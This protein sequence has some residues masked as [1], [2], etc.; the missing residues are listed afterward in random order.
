[1][2][3]S[4]LIAQIM[5]LRELL[6]SFLGN[7]LV[8]GIV[9]ANWLLLEAGG[10]LLVGRLL[11]RRGRVF[12]S[13][14]AT[15]L[16]FALALPVSIYG[17]RVFKSVVLR[18]P[19][20]A[21]GFLPILGLSLLILL[22]TAVPHGALFTMG[23]RLRSLYVPDAGNSP[24]GSRTSSS[25]FAS[26]RA[27]SIGRVYVLESLGSILGGAAFTFVLVRR[28]D[29]L[30]VAWG[31]SLAN[32]LISLIL[33]RP[34]R[35]TH[36]LSPEPGRRS[37]R[38][39]ALLLVLIF[40]L[41]LFSPLGEPIHLSS[42]RR[43]WPGLEP[44][45]SENSIYGNITVTRTA[46][47]RTF[48]TDGVPAATVPVPDIGGIETFVH[49]PMLLHHRPESVLIAGGGAGGMIGEVLKHPVGRIDYVELDPL[50]IQLIL[51][52]GS[53]A[54][55]RE[56]TDPRV[57]IHHSDARLFL[58]R[59]DRR[60]DVVFIGIGAPQELQ[61]N[62]LFTR[63]FFS[64][65][66]EKLGARGLLA[67]SLPGSQTYMG[68]ELR[69]LNGCILDTLESVF[70]R[71]RVVPGDENL[72][73]ASDSPLSVQGSADDLIARL[74][75]RNIAANLVSP[76]YIEY[77]LQPQWL[78]DYRRAVDPLPRRINSDFR[79]LAVFY[80]LSYWNALYSPAVGEV[81]RRIE[82]TRPSTVAVLILIATLGVAVLSA[83]GRTGRG[84]PLFHAIA[85]TGFCGMI[86][87][88][89]VILTF[90]TLFGYLYVQIGLLVTVFM[91]GTVMGS[92][93]ATRLLERREGG[94]TAFLAAELCLALFAMLLP[95]ALIGP[96]RLLDQP[97]VR[98]LHHALFLLVSLASGALTGFQFPLAA[99]LH[100]RSAA[101]GGAEIPSAAEQLG[102]R[103]G[104]EAGD[105]AGVLY[106]ADLLGGYFGGLV[107]GVILLPILGLW[108]TCLILAMIKGGSLLV[109]LVRFRATCRRA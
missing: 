27:S 1:M 39:A 44:V 85:T 26:A 100:L 90:Q 7:E 10:A 79:P 96:S 31:V 72:Y 32:A 16:L 89:A 4:G 29:S 63:E 94:Q 104:G 64:T 30:A 41:L 82:G 49:L 84:I 81:F 62:R 76:P 14:L 87:D 59:T 38:G 15:Q 46:E 21:L 55:R 28:F 108:S 102:R 48:F 19:G 43:R 98:L 105:T 54:T 2:G 101:A 18:V 91:A 35:R 17:S 6:V 22:P 8:L 47:Q 50:L 67:L 33:L 51:S 13:F 40:V 9:L 34:N 95:L 83:T 52:H 74:R 78:S 97:A 53:A 23:S 69:Q 103:A 68:E 45:T 3:A 65:A 99:D 42:I 66:R 57:E 56:L 36:P 109:S 70:A 5:L 61:T 93:L 88:L 75:E 73:V 107:G 12:D 11:G 77:R 86:F 37:L 71:V 106:G 25:R 20:Q 80:G 60:Y 92:L 24:R 58:T